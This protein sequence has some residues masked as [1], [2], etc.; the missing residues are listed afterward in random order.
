MCK[1]TSPFLFMSHILCRNVVKLKSLY[2]ICE[3][4]TLIYEKNL[5][6]YSLED[7]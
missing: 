1:Y 6:K 7:R 5:E 2:K 3:I 4:I